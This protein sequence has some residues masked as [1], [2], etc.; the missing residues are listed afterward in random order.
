M[1]VASGM[2]ILTCAAFSLCIF[3]WCN[4]AAQQA[5]SRSTIMSRG[6]GE[7]LRPGRRLGESAVAHQEL[8]VNPLPLRRAQEVHEMRGVL[9]RAET[10]ERRLADTAGPHLAGHPAGAHRPG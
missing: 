2:S 8:A 4:S 7:R 5:A 6:A 10:A 3:R 9:W 1:L